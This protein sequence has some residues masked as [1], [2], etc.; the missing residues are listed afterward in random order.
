EPAGD[1][2]HAVVFWLLA[3]GTAALLRLRFGINLL[4]IFR[5]KLARGIVTGSGILEIVVTDSRVDP[6]SRPGASGLR[7]Y[8][9]VN[10][11]RLMS[12]ARS[13]CFRVRAVHRSHAGNVSTDLGRVKLGRPSDCQPGFQRIEHADTHIDVALLEV[14]QIRSK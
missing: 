12:H 1:V 3:G 8:G 11:T 14:R 7:K 6:G 2:Q 4:Q 13:S 9:I 10:K 5:V